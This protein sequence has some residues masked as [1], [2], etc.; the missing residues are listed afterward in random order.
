MKILHL[1]TRPDWRGGQH[2]ILMTLRGQ[3]ERGHD[4]Q[5]L[6]RR[7]SRLAQR[8]TSEKVTVHTFSPRFARLDAFLCLREAMRQQRFDVIHAHDPHALSAAWLARAQAGSALLAS[9]RVAYPLSRGWPGLARYRAADRI[10]AVSQ[11]VAASVL[12]AGIDANRVAVVY[13]GVEIPAVTSAEGR[14]AARHR[15]NTPDATPLLGCVGYLLPEKGQ[16]VL[17]RAMKTIVT[18][19]PASKLLL[20]GDG[21]MRARLESLAQELSLGDSVIFAGF[22]ADTDAVYRALDL[23]VFPSLAEP[24]GSSLL[25]AMAHGLPAVAVASGGVREVI[26][27]G[28]NGVLVPSSDATAFAN[29]VCTLWRDPQTAQRLSNAARE[30][31]AQ[32]FTAALLAEKTLQEYE[33]AIRSH[34]ISDNL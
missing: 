8:A 2:Q 15:W 3:H 21:P 7:S 14:A 24:L 5:L 17:L 13:D 11:F 6:T 12:A 32:R 4:A 29:A 23:F 26:E 25:A 19:F 20:A 28:R 31:V 22:V 18:E 1:D 34:C 30:T 9:R 10:I 27:D 33:R 16:D